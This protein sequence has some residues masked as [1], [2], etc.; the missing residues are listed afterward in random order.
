MWQFL[1]IFMTNTFFRLSFSPLP[2]HL[3]SQSPVQSNL[4]YAII[5]DRTDKILGALL[6]LSLNHSP[7]LACIGTGGIMF[8][9]IFY[10]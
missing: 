1:L 9:R 2:F 3:V 7:D 6:P 8:K 5:P 4:V 10:V